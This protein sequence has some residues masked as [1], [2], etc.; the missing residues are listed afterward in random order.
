MLSSGHLVEV[1]G[2]AESKPFEMEQMN[3]MIA[4]ASK[5]ITDLFKIQSASLIDWKNRI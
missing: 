1:Q 3:N 5:G 2:T 4:L